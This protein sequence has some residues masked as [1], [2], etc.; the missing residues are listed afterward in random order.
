MNVFQNALG[1]VISSIREYPIAYNTAIKVGQIVK[2]SG[3]LV[4]LAVAGETGAILGIAMENHSGVADCLDP[5]SNGTSILVCDDP[6]VI[7]ECKAPQLTA[8]GGSSTT[9]V[10]TIAGAA[11]V[12]N[13][14]Y[15][16]LVAKAA[17]STNT[18]EIGTIK[19]IADFA[20]SEG[21]GTF[22]VASGGAANSGDV[23][24]V[25]PPLGFQGGNFDSAISGLVLSSTA[26]ISA[27]VVGHDTKF[28]KLRMMFTKHFLGNI[29]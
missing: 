27:K 23:Y 11:D 1:H 20:T 15:L 6:A 5:R 22:T 25:Y 14:G 8:S 24:E 12:Y 3:G 18:D 7:S 10:G 16:K 19:Q 4:V 13:G 28:G 9:V 29:G 21:V 2:I 26:A 17:G